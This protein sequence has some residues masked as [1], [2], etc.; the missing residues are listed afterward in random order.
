[1][2]RHA[3]GALGGVGTRVGWGGARA[4]GGGSAQPGGCGCCSGD[5]RS[6]GQTTVHRGLEGL[7]ASGG[8]TNASVPSGAPANEPPGAATD[9]IP[10][11]T[12]PP[13]ARAPVAS[14]PPAGRAPPHA[15]PHGGG[16]ASSSHGVAPAVAPAVDDSLA[17]GNGSAAAN[18]DRAANGTRGTDEAAAPDVDQIE[19]GA[20]ADSPEER[21]AEGPSRAQLLGLWPKQSRAAEEAA[22]ASVFGFAPGNYG[23]DQAASTVHPAN[24]N[25]AA[26]EDGSG[27]R[28]T[29][30]AASVNGAQAANEGGAADAS[31]VIDLT[32]EDDGEGDD[33]A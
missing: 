31:E 8:P 21:C 15:P 17:P 16:V 7:I 14:D 9:L 23:T 12:D 10:P 32:E 5:A 22:I 2:G 1:A 30:Q 11:A 25:R 13:R 20:V 29:D 6:A 28:G 19:A 27:N 4:K 3:A 33:L 18:E 24:E 26:D